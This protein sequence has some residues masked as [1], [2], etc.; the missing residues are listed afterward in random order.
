MWRV[1]FTFSSLTSC[2]FYAF[3]AAF[4]VPEV[5]TALWYINLVYELIFLISMCLQFVTEYKPQGEMSKPV[6]D[7]GLIS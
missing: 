3:I 7:I 1:L 6:R 5:E 2:Y 4:G